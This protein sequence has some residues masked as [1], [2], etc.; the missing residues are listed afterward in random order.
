MKI[1][2]ISKYGVATCFLCVSQFSNAGFLNIEINHLGGLSTSQASTFDEA[3]NYWESI[4]TGIQA[5]FN[6]NLVIDAQ[7]KYIDGENG[8]LGS[9]GP[10]FVRIDNGFAFATAGI[11]KF[12]TADL[13]ALEANNSLFDVIL[14]EMAH[15]IG[16]G[17]LWDIGSNDDEVFAGTQNVYTNDSGE[18]TGAYGLA[19]Y[20]KEFDSD[21]S[22]VPVDTVSGP[23]TANG[24]WDENWAGGRTDLMT[25]FLDS[26]L[27]LSRTTIASFAD[28]G[29]TTYIT[30]PVPAPSALGMFLIGLAFALRKKR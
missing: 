2:N 12:D 6:L 3:T 16:F 28:I 13:S 5:D 25:G 8:V 24:H 20:K 7:G 23:G 22:F 9:A 19:E 17:T 1:K 15:V 14:H 26:N 27:T 11:M 29:Y 21:A 30:H 10:T 4:L 18:Y